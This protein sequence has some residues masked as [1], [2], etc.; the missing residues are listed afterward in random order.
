MQAVIAVRGAQ[1]VDH[2]DKFYK[3]PLMIAAAEGDTELVKFF[4]ENG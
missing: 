3:T 4:I 1:M 2:R